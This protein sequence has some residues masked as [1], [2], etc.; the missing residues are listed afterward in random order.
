M[1]A[2]VAPSRATA[3]DH[4]KRAIMNRLGSELGPASTGRLSQPFRRAYPAITETGARATQGYAALG[5]S[6]RHRVQLG[7]H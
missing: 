6:A 1:R 3:V 4:L 5:L 2:P 7:M